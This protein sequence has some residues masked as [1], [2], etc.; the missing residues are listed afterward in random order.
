MNIAS[1]TDAACG[2]SNGSATIDFNGGIP[3]YAVNLNGNPYGTFSNTLT[4]YGL[5]PGS[6]GISAT[7][8]NNTLCTGMVGFN[9][10][11]FGTPPLLTLNITQP[12]CINCFDG[13]VSAIVTGGSAPYTYIWSNG[14]TMSSL[15]NLSMGNYIVIVTDA[16]GCTAIDTAFLNV[17]PPNNYLLGGKVFFD[18]NNDSV[19]SNGDLLLANQ[20]VKNLN[21]S[22]IAY[23]NSYGE[24]YFAAPN[25][26]Y[27][28]AFEPSSSSPFQNVNGPDTII[29][30]INNQASVNNDFAVYPDSTY[31][32]YYGFSNFYLP[33]C[34]TTQVLVTTVSNYGSTSD[35]L[36][37]NVDFPT[38]L[39]FQGSIS[40]ATI[41]G[42]TIQYTSAL[43]QPGQS[44]NFYSYFTLPAP[45]FLPAMTTSVVAYNQGNSY[46][47]DTTS[48][49]VLVICSCDPND[50]TV[51]P[52]LA[53]IGL[54]KQLY[55]KI[56][57]QNTGNDTAINVVVV[58]TLSSL[59]DVNSLHFLSSSHN[60]SVSR[61]GNV[62]SFSFNNIFLPDSNVNEPASHG[63]LN[64]AIDVLN[65]SISQTVE[66]IAAI[67]FDVND[68]VITNIAAVSFVACVGIDEYLSK[69]EIKVFPNPASD[70][71]DLNL[72]TTCEYDYIIYSNSGQQLTSQQ[73]LKNNR[74]FLPKS[75]AG[76]LLI[77][78]VINRTQNCKSFSKIL[79]H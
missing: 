58:D 4:I 37:I 53:Y 24:Y 35:S 73:L 11:S 27:S 52:S 41:N 38:N 19:Y 14:S 70:Y 77:L 49:S 44:Q 28:L 56:R 55:Y 65:N 36:T 7:D 25:G 23:S 20:M 26:S 9:I 79:T 5:A 60:C 61:N 68:P 67:Y 42:N 54:D 22:T 64:F 33:R 39:S 76:Q 12:S 46:S 3:P 51:S 6:Y 32:L 57:F 48:T 62:V 66:N 50:K 8:G 59:L 47:M 10:S 17:L 69:D 29:T 45:G 71:V 16:N 75:E 78:E 63:Y 18:A 21:D 34:Y 13:S 72:D 43:L 1:T 31:R 74:V 30:S 15:M 40:S 2:Q